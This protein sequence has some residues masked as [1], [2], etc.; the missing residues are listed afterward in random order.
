MKHYKTIYKIPIANYHEYLNTGNPVYIA[1]FSQNNESS[2]LD[3]FNPP[4]KCPSKFKNI[5]EEMQYQFEE[6]NIT[7]SIRDEVKLIDLTIELLTKEIL[8]GKKPHPNKR[9]QAEQLKK[10]IELE[11]KNTTSL[12]ERIRNIDAILDYK[13][14]IDKFTLSFASFINLEK[15]AYERVEANKTRKQNSFS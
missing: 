6:Y 13:I 14:P 11:N 4:T 3:F 12:D 9:H 15:T 1:V 5:A 2:D 10:S 7:D 8:T